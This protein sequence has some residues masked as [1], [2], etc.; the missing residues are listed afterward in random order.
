MNKQW[1]MQGDLQ[2]MVQ[3]LP[4]APNSVFVSQRSVG[5]EPASPS[6]NSPDTE[7]P[8][9]TSAPHTETSAVNQQEQTPKYL[10]LK[11]C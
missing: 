4:A 7:S 2:K 11:A 9:L 5:A 3:C 1:K 6:T 8:I 10:I